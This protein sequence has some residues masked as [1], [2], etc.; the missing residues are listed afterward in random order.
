MEINIKYIEAAVQIRMEAIKVVKDASEQQKQIM[1]LSAEIELINE[2]LAN[3][4]LTDKSVEEIQANVVEKL[5]DIEKKGVELA[6]IINPINDKMT[7]LKKQE[8]ILYD[9]IK[10]SYPNI[11]DDEIVEQLKKYITE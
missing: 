2:E 5:A 8:E 9:A 6:K 7:S 3:V 4:P 10:T 1:K 11:S